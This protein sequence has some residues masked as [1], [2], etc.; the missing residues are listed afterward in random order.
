MFCVNINSIFNFPSLNVEE[1]NMLLDYHVSC[2]G[3]SYLVIPIDKLKT[4]PITLI[5]NMRNVSS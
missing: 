2:T 4:G 3:Y 1:H 5:P